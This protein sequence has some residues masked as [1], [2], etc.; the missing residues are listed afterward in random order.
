MV[1]QQ[2]LAMATSAIFVMVY[3]RISVRPGV[4]CS[5]VKG[6]WLMPR[7]SMVFGLGFPAGVT[8]LLA[9][10][11]RRPGL[12]FDQF[13]LFTMATIPVA[14]RRICMMYFVLT[15]SEQLSYDP[16]SSLN[17]CTVAI[18]SFDE[19]AVLYFSLPLSICVT[20]HKTCNRHSER[21]RS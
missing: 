7:L 21:A 20:R 4:S 8:F 16:I 5:T 17:V 19:M 1:Y 13:S 11:K 10:L 12:H 18:S 2:V 6:M 9:R 15:A 14:F 3:R